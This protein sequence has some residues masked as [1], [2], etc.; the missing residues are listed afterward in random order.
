MKSDKQTEKYRMLSWVF[1][2]LSLLFMGMIFWFSSRDAGQ[3]G[4]MSLPLAQL[5]HLPEWLVRKG[6]HMTEYA[7][8][9]VLY[10]GTCACRFGVPYRNCIQKEAADMKRAGEKPDKKAEVWTDRK[11][12]LAAWSMAVCYAATD[13]L[14]QWF[15]PGRSCEVRDVCVDG[16][17]ALIGCLAA[18]EIWKLIRKHENE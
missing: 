13:E 16:A 3:S 6:A 12:L 5:F 14:H 9:G 1:L 15:V 18:A 2:V 17:G 10:S 4:S 11:I 7:V 8:L